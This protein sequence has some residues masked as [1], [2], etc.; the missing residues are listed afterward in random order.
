MT[1][2]VTTLSAVVLRL[3]GLSY[4]CTVLSVAKERHSEKMIRR[5]GRVVEG[6]A[7]ER[8]LSSEEGTRVRIPFSPLEI[9]GAV[10]EW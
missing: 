8:Q 4:D 3:N 1:G 7:L 6:A 10:T 5:G 2:A 9:H